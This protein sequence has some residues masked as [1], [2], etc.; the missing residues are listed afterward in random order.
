MATLVETI[1]GKDVIMIDANAAHQASSDY[2]VEKFVFTDGFDPHDRGD[3]SAPCSSRLRGA[4]YR[5]EATG[6]RQPACKA[7]P[8]G[9]MQGAQTLR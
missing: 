2:G 4:G 8:T 7:T 5:Y 9:A 3:P 1:N 6:V